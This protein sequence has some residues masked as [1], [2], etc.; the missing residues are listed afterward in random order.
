MGF[1]SLRVINEDKVAADGGFPTHPHR[2]MEIFSYIVNGALAHSDSMGNQRTLLPGEI[3]LMSAG[4]GVRHS[5]FNP[6]KIDPVHFLQIWI[7]P[8]SK[9]LTPSYTE[10]KPDPTRDGDRKVLVIS[11]DGRE[12]SAKIN[13]DADVFRIRLQPGDSVDHALREGRGI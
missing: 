1:R 11:A 13:Q 12:N 6:S 2:D 3:Q 7:E 4:A 9:A 8:S 5:E 10:W